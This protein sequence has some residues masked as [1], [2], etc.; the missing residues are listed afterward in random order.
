MNFSRIMII[1]GTPPS[2]L[3]AVLDAIAS[4]GGGVIGHYTY[5]SFTNTG[6]GRFK[7]DEAAN[8]AVGEKA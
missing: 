6:I 8:P 2:G 5:C 3:Q 1:V 4:A 7:P